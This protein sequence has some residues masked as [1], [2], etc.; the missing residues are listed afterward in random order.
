[1]LRHIIYNSKSAREVSAIKVKYSELK[2]MDV[3][4]I[5][6]GKNLGRV[7]DITFSS[8]EN[9]VSGLTASGGRGFKFTKEEV[10][11]PIESIVKIGEDV[12]LTNFDARKIEPA[13]GGKPCP[14]RPDRRS[15]EDY[16]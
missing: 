12:V 11:L 1:M 4:S 3:I 10:F 14:P 9:R 5:T 13:G 15:Y 16:E 6:D 2:K 7:N 8:P